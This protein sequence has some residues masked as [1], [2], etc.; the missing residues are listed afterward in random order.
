M[1]G[2]KQAGDAVVNNQIKDET[3]I[4]GAA[5]VVY[6]ISVT[7]RVQS[8]LFGEMST[9]LEEGARVGVDV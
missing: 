6:P 3:V 8:R 1:L 5:E 7:D 9:G 4:S 2:I